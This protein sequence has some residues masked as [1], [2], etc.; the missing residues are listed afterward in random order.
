MKLT[1]TVAGLLLLMSGADPGGNGNPPSHS[2]L[3]AEQPTLNVA[4]HEPP[5]AEVA[6][7]GSAPDFS[8]QGPDSRWR[9][10]HDLTSQGVVL[11]V[12]GAA[13]RD[14]EAMES[15]RDALLDL[16]VIPVAVLDMKPS[17]AWASAR[18]LGLRYTVL[19]DPRR[20]IGHQFNSIDTSRPV[21]IPSWFLIDHRRTV[22]G[23]QHGPLPK[24][25]FTK[26]AAL[27]LGLPHPGAT[28]STCK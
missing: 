12:F 3:T 18:R 15:E 27:A 24:Q 17:R 13:E 9:H 10:L 6:V 5:Q 2:S 26:L 22:R 14:L 19:A 1:I 23:L 20:V 4:T 11:L 21:T 16:R 25:G 7:G 28:V 8:Y